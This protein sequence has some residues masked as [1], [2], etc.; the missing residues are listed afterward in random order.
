M[1]GF[2][3]LGWG[4]R[5]LCDGEGTALDLFLSLLGRVAVHP[6]HVADVALIW[7]LSNVPSSGM[8]P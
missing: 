5:E 2:L 6:V 1:C 8:S 3:F 4:G 7:P